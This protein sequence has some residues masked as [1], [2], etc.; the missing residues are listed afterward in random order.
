[1]KDDAELR[2][3]T[4]GW[5]HNIGKVWITRDLIKVFGKRAGPY[6][7]DEPILDDDTWAAVDEAAPVLN[8]RLAAW[9]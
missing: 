2:T 4:F 1:M 3:F 5:F 9:L 8:Q 7:H 6:G